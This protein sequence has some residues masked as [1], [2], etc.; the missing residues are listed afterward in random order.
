MLGLTSQYGLV[1]AVAALSVLSGAAL[2]THDAVVLGAEGLLGQRLV[3]L[4]TAETLLVPVPALMVELLVEEE[5]GR[6]VEV[7]LEVRGKK[8]LHNLKR[9]TCSRHLGF[10]RDGSVALGAGVGAELGVAADAHGPTLA[11]DEP[12]PPEVF[13]TVVTVGAL[14]HG[15]TE[16]DSHLQQAEGGGR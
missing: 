10:K 3:T 6:K 9:N 8:T 16:G 5:R 13:P 4:G 12:L 2:S 1:A 14:C 11:A 15:C 7:S